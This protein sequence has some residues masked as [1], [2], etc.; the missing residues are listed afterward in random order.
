METYKFS[1]GGLKALVKAYGQ[2]TNRQVAKKR[3][4]E[5]EVWF[6]LCRKTNWDN[7]SNHIILYY[8]HKV[9]GVEDLYKKSVERREK[10]RQEDEKYEA[11]LKEI[12]ETLKLGDILVDDD[13]GTEWVVIGADN[14]TTTIK[15][16]RGKMEMD[17]E[18]G[19][20]SWE[21]VLEENDN[22]ELP[23]RDPIQFSQMFIKV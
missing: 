2:L 22:G 13:E 10:K 9:K 3:K 18:G 1:S 16:R 6:N 5:D 23:D 4:I 17:I 12:E 21:E 7:N 19:K 20:G 11:N 14:Y 15:K 8:L